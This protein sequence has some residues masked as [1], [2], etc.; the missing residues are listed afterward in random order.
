MNYEEMKMKLF[1]NNGAL[2]LLQYVE[3]KSEGMVMV[4]EMFP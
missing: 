3:C 1:E 2:V 4:V